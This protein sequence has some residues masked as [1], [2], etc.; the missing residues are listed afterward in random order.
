VLFW[1]NSG[2][3][4]LQRVLQEKAT[5]V[6]DASAN[7]HDYITAYVSGATM[8]NVR[9]VYS[10][11]NGFYLLILPDQSITFCFDVR[12]ALEDGSLRM[13]EWPGFAP[14]AAATRLDE[15][16][17]FGVPGRLARY[18]GYRDNTS[19]Y[20][21]EYRSPWT[22]FSEPSGL[23]LSKEMSAVLLAPQ[24][25]PVVFRWWTD[26]K[27]NVH[28]TQKELNGGAIAEYGTAEYGVDEYSGGIT[29][30]DL[31][32]PMVGASEWRFA[33]FGIATDIDGF[34]FAIQSM[35]VYAQRGRMV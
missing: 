7:N 6:N 34:P 13:T 4:S 20:R 14:T 17:L 19:S 12:K 11:R 22:D 32:A 18:Y 35:S 26:F 30:K 5:P 27:A 33:S 2:V 28:S 25:T 9:S 10:S 8:D 16:V 1:S 3:R 29:V 15:T 24:N 21:F 23:K 31:R